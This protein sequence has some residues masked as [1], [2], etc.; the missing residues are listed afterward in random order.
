MRWGHVGGGLSVD[1]ANA[2]SRQHVKRLT[3]DPQIQT[4]RGAGWPTR[5]VILKLRHSPFK[6]V[7]VRRAL[8]GYGL[9][10]QAIAK[11]AL[12]GAGAAPV[13]F[14]ATEKRRSH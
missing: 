1:F 6:D 4:L 7:R 12:L 5:Q 8:S 13:E 10:R 9:D 2:I 11:T 3:R 14:C